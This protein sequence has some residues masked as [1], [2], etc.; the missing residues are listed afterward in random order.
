MPNLRLSTFNAENLFARY[1]FKNSIQPTA[2]PGFTINIT[3]FRIH[4]EEAKKIT[5][6]AIRAADADVICLQEVESLPVLDRFNSFHLGGHEIRPSRCSA[7]FRSPAPTGR[8][9][10]TA[11]GTPDRLHPFGNQGRPARLH[12]GAGF[13]VRRVKLAEQRKP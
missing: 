9:R 4:D 7:N 11:G 10:L 5:A 3:A 8:T 1:R 13:V 2:D 12:V 6:K